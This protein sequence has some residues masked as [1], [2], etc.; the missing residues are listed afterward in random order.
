MDGDE[1]IGWQ[2]KLHFSNGVFLFFIFTVA[3][4]TTHLGGFTTFRRKMRKIKA[5][6]S[7]CYIPL[8]SACSVSLQTLEK[9]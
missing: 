2:F 6:T 7:S 9:H 8:D 1:T 4:R 5:L 3:M